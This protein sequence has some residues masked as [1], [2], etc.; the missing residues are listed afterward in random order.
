MNGEIG[1]ESE[2]GKG[3]R[4]WFTSVFGKLDVAHKQKG[5]Y[6]DEFDMQPQYLKIRWN[7]F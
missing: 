5:N 2:E 6:V 4:F 3:S 1:Y 7:T